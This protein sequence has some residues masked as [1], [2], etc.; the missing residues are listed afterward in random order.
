MYLPAQ[1]DELF[2]KVGTPNVLPWKY[3]MSFW[4][5]LSSKKRSTC[6]VLPTMALFWTNWHWILKS[7][8][9]EIFI[10]WNVGTTSNY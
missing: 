2:L 6:Y 10:L 8:K 4:G 7:S 9:V 5:N 1:S 3:I